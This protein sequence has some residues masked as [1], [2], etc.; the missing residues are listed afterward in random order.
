M[1]LMDPNIRFYRMKYMP[2]LI[3]LLD[4]MLTK[5]DEKIRKSIIR[6]EAPMPDSFNT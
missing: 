5:V 2:D 3:K 1:F 4:R 6:I